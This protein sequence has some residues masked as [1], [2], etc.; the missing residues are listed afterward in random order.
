MLTSYVRNVFLATVGFLTACS[1]PPTTGAGGAAPLGCDTAADCGDSHPDICI[2]CHANECVVI[3]GACNAC[4]GAP[5]G[6]IC[7]GTASDAI[8]GECDGDPAAPV[9]DVTEWTCLRNP[10]GTPCIG[11]LCDG[12]DTCCSGGCLSAT[13][14]CT[15]G[16]GSIGKVCS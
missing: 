6:T 8:H 12:Q 3:S 14:V 10:P 15:F 9:C 11:G 16:A 5:A 4:E 7:E 1:S 13:N 2:A